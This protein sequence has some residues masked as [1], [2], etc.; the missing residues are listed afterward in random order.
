MEGEENM[1]T[2]IVD[3]SEKSSAPHVIESLKKYFNVVVANLPHRTYGNTSITAG[4]INIPLED[5]NLLAIERKTGSDLLNSIK[6]RHILNQIEVMH[7]YAKWCA[8][9]VT[10]KILYSPNDMVIV[11][12]K[13]TE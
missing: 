6:D 2:I 11:D 9:I 4:D 1:I 8:I 10:S 13:E 7:T 3:K 5:G 12:K